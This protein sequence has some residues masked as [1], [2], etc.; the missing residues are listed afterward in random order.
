MIHNQKSALLD[1]L[2]SQANTIAKS[3]A[4]VTSDAMVTDD[5]S[6]IVEHIQKVLNDS[7]EIKYIIMSKKDEQSVYNDAQ[8]WTILES[9]PT[10]LSALESEKIQSEILVSSL[11]EHEVY[12]FTYPIMFSGIKWGWISIGLSLEQYNANMRSIYK[13]SFLLIVAMFVAT[14][15]FSYIITGWLVQPILILN[16]AARKIADGDLS[17]KVDISQ[18]GEIGEL[19]LSF[20]HMID[21]LK[22][23][24]KE[25]RSANDALEQRVAQRT[26]ELYLLNKQLDNRVKEETLK[27]AEQ[28][29]ILIQQ[30]RFAAMGEMIGNIAHQWRQPLNALGLLMQNI[31]YAYESKSLND[32]Y[33]KRVVEKGNRLTQSMSQTIDDFRNFFK[34]N[35]DFEVFSYAQAY[36]ST[37]AMI[38]SSILNNMIEISENIDKSVCVNGFSSEFSQVLLNILNNAKDALV[39]NQEQERHIYITIY[40]EDE[41]AYFTIEDNAGGIQDEIITKVFDPYFTT[42][43]EGKGTGIGLY[44][45]KTIIESNMHGTLKVENTN[46]GARFTIKMKLHPCNTDTLSS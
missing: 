28:E 34:P 25:L 44:M 13:D 36:K 15:L 5:E 9:L 10:N 1:V 38:G 17:V 11:Y 41:Y 4:L 39:G 27:K 18:K 40:K 3:L 29:Q 30:S 37:M 32:E 7:D 45:S 31:E 26:Q 24:D 42:K 46:L 21:A 33:I 12:H 8:H 20:N 23:S 14:I 2:N 43:D 6:F 16:K 22:I 35:K 19:A